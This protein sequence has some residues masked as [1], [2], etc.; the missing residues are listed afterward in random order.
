MGGTRALIWESGD[1]ASLSPFVRNWSCDLGQVDLS[2]GVHCLCRGAGAT[3]PAPFTV[4]IVLSG[5]VGFL[6]A[7]K[8]LWLMNNCF[9]GRGGQVTT[10]SEDVWGTRVWDD[11]R[12]QHSEELG[13]DLLSGFCCRLDGRWP[14]WPPAHTCHP[15]LPRPGGAVIDV[16]AAKPLP[17]TCRCH[18]LPFSTLQTSYVPVENRWL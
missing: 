1:L 7:A 5:P 4:H 14:W 10:M 17:C 11:F 12:Q 8:C 15:E 16:A 3:T 9:R 13:N 18:A 2:S 6:T